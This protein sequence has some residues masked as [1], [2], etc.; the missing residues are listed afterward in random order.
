MAVVFTV[1]RKPATT[2]VIDGVTQRA[3]TCIQADWTID[4]GVT[5]NGTTGQYF[6]GKVVRCTTVPGAPIPTNLYG[7]AITEAAGAGADVITALGAGR[8]NVLV[9]TIAPVVSVVSPGFHILNQQLTFTI[10]ASALN[11]QGTVYLFIE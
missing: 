3:V 4:V 8:S 6:S 9:Q 10:T 2:A 1:T 5:V 7:V 11:S